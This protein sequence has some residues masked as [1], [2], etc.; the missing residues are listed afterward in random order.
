M[1]LDASA[2][3]SEDG[4]ETAL[5]LV[6]RY[7][8]EPLRVSLSFEGMA[9][10]ARGRLRQLAAD[11]PFARNSFEHPD[12]LRIQELPLPSV[13]QIELPPH[14]VSAIVLS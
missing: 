7:M 5:F 2:T 12:R 8:D 10:P 4:G 13:S 9:A 11:S 1:N 3:A 14:S 6:N